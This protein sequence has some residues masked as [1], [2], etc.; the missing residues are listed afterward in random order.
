MRN[1]SEA[2]HH[3]PDRFK[4][5]EMCKKS[6]VVESS[7]LQSVPNWFVT[8]EGLFMWHDDYYDGNDGDYWDDDDDDDQ[9]FKWYDGHKKRKAQKAKIKEKRLP[10]AS[11]PSRWW[12]RCVHENE[13][14]E[15]EKLWK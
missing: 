13:K 10:I 1:M 7:S 14:K 11:H 6:V 3:V 9:L 2:L 12:D 4:N 8:R 5:K 15:T